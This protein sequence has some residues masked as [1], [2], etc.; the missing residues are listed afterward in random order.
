MTFVT[1]LTRQFPLTVDIAPYEPAD[2][3]PSLDQDL[4]R[5]NGRPVLLKIWEWRGESDRR[6]KYFEMAI[7][8]DGDA[9]ATLLQQVLANLPPKPK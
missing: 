8:V 1:S 6:R 2:G 4:Q 7:P 5:S 9:L 3:D